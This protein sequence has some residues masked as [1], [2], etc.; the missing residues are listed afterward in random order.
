MRLNWYKTLPEGYKAMKGLEKIAGESKLESMLK[1]L[2]RI[3]AS[4]ING[5]A[6]CIDMHTKDARALGENEQRIY[7]LSAWR[8]TALYSQRERQLLHGVSH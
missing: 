7:L 8:E 4:Q 5:C 2:V 6:Y 1:E 3:R